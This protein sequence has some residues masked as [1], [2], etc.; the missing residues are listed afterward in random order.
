MNSTSHIVLLKGTQLQIT[1]ERLCRQ[2]IEHHNNFESSAL[3]GLQ[4]RGILLAEVIHKRLEE[5]TNRRIRY[6]KLDAT[7]H[8][9]DFR[10]HKGPILPSAMQINFS[11]ED[12]NVVLIDDVLFTGRTIRSGLDALIDLGRPSKVELLVLVDRRYSRQLPIQ[13]DYTGISVDSRTSEK[14]QVNWSLDKTESSIW[15]I[16]ADESITN[17]IATL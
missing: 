3:L 17:D 13:P 16:K 2:L 9:D 5:I 7:F 15:L 6:G 8:R 10:T 1:I 12:L 11:I 4:P 14:I